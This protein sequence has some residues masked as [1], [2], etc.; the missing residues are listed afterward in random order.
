MKPFWLVEICYYAAGGRGPFVPV[1][2]LFIKPAK[3][4]ANASF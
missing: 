3:K 4:D 2:P 1:L